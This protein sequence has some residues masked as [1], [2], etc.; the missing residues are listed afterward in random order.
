LI[1]MKNTNRI[2]LPSGSIIFFLINIP[3]LYLSFLISEKIRLNP[4]GHSAAFIFSLLVFL[5]PIIAAL[6][7]NV[8]SSLSE[9]LKIKNI[10]FISAPL[11]FSPL[12]LY[13]FKI[14]IPI[15]LC[16]S[17]FIIFLF[18]SLAASVIFSGKGEKEK[19]KK[20][21]AYFPCIILLLSEALFALSAR[22]I[23]K[24]ESTFLRNRVDEGIIILAIL[25]VS[26]FLAS[27]LSARKINLSESFRRI[28]S[29]RG[30]KI[31]LVILYIFIPVVIF[32][33]A[34]DAMPHIQDEVAYLFQAKVLASGKLYAQSPP[35][36]KFF[37]YEFIV[38]DGAKWYGKYFAGSSLLLAAGILFNVPWL[39]NPLLGAIAVFLFYLF[40]K[41]NTDGNSSSLMLILPLFSPFL[42]FIDASYLSH[43]KLSFFSHTFSLF[44]F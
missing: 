24:L 20:K 30:I 40:L 10:L 28:L 42:I 16:L 32:F 17:Y 11:S 26:L 22:F 4:P 8:Y 43:T 37:D 39:I 15:S 23:G 38:T 18:I 9:I 12:I 2:S 29:G 21:T 5:Y 33:T 35:I 27:A 7:L 13:F 14:Y 44:F 1:N 34:L 31:I 3:I 6:F 41:E 19:N 36:P 25:S